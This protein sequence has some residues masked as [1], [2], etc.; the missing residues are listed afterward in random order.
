MDQQPRDAADFLAQ[1]ERC[2]RLAKIAP[3]TL[4]AQLLQWADEFAAKAAALG[5]DRRREPR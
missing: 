4:I 3:E 2:R 1:A 5:G